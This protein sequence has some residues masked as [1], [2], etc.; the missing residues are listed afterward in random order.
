MNEKLNIQHLIDLLA[1][2]HHIPP[3]DAEGFVKAFFALIEEGL[4]QDRYVKI[5]GLG[6]FKL[7][8]VESRG[9]VDV[10]TGERIEIQG[11]TK[12]SFTPDSALKEIINRPFGHFET[13]IL[14]EG[15][16][17]EDTP[18]EKE[19]EEEGE[20]GI[21]SL[22]DMENKAAPMTE[23]PSQVEGVSAE[24][25]QERGA[26]VVAEEEKEKKPL[27]T[28]SGLLPA[29]GKGSGMKW[30]VGLLVCVLLVCAGVVGYLYFPEMQ[31]APVL[32]AGQKQEAVQAADAFVEKKDTVR[33][34]LSE[35]VETPVAEKNKF[36][37]EMPQKNV[38]KTPVKKAQPVIPD[39]VNYEI[40]GTI[41]AYTVK[42]GETLTRISLRFYGTK[43]LWPYIVKH[44][45]NVLKDP[46][47]VVS[48]TVLSIPKLIKKQ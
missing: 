30:L 38:K 39:S 17:L 11:H 3:K 27:E 43:A 15:T 16:V 41:T 29:K 19:E 7:I 22:Q 8:E 40:T 1:D 46:D 31:T 44:N 21:V 28:E 10:N 4:E 12:V 36:Q 47:N 5:K 33:N 2:K 9:S 25:E 18:V 23:S 34:A 37:A 14:N 13:V 32:P 26:A 35:K 6:T 24:P 42:E 48:G 20:E 45:V